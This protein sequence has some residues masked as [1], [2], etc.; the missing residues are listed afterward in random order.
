ME[1]NI[2]ISIVLPVFNEE[3]NIVSLL[4]EIVSVCENEIKESYEI[5]VVD[6][7]STD[8]SVQKIQNLQEELRTAG[9]TPCLDKIIILKQAVNSG[10]SAAIMAGMRISCGT[11]ILTMDADLQHD[12]SDIPAFI[13][14]IQ[15]CD[16]VCGIR[17]K[18]SDGAAR[19]LCSKIANLFRNLVTGDNIHDSGCTFRLMKRKC[20]ASALLVD[21][22][23]YGCEFF[24]H[25]L[26]IR[27]DGFKVSEIKINHRSRPAGSS[28]YGLI[29]GRL[30]KGIKAIF[31]VK[32]FLLFYKSTER[33]VSNK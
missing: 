11:L 29:S 19:F 20:I 21:G 27:K 16:M 6:D 12:P 13:E 9:R 8:G 30:L 28:H 18:R 31:K 1:K 2:Y 26:L 17:K 25:P 32:S 24:F 10:Q 22:K 5:V 4:K 33:S 23:L 14:K 3:N 15:N 7:A